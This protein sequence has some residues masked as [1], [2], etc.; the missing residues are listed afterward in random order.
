MRNTFMSLRKLGTDAIIIIRDYTAGWKR[1]H[2]NNIFFTQ[3]ID[4]VNYVGQQQFQLENQ[5]F[6]RE[7]FH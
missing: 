7:S 3:E 2:F 4:C 6:L 1:F 5:R